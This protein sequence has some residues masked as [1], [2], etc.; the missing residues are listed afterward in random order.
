MLKRIQDETK[1][2]LKNSIAQLENSSKS[3][4]IKRP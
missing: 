4:T 2:E 3:D 1:C